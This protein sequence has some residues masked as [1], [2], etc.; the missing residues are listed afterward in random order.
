MRI[1]T[2]NPLEGRRLLVAVSGSIAAVKVP[3]L[4]SSLVKA[5]AKVRCLVTPSASELVSPVSLATLSRHR[6]Y[7]DQDQWAATEPRPLH[8]HLAEWAE[9]VIVAPLSAASLAR[10]THGLADGLLASTLLACERPIVAV[11]AMNTAMW[12]NQA[13]KRNWL[14]LKTFARVLTIGPGMGLLACDRVG[15]GRM[16]SPELIQLACESVLFTAD[17]SGVVRHDWQGLRLL[18]S[19]GPTV[20]GIDAARLMTN[21]SSGKM[22]VLLA[23]AARFRGAQVDLVHGPLRLPQQWLE[24]L[25]TYPVESSAEM[26]S[27]LMALHGC[28][29]AVAMAA[30]VSD[31]RHTGLIEISKSAKQA[32][33]MSLKEGW[34][35][36]PDLLAELA[37]KRPAGQKLIGF[38][39]LTGD[40]ASLIERA[41]TKFA[42]KGCDLLMVNPIDRPGQGFDCSENGGWILGKDGQ[43]RKMPVVAKM[44]LAHQLLDALLDLRPFLKQ[45]S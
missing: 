2:R 16:A 4:V 18:V 22:G 43:E 29:D 41:A 37:L 32:L 31:V 26:R 40:D 17:E 30:A 5:G 15:D 42:D 8:V 9:L 12:A 10:W 11:A 28:V 6:C 39:A 21:R 19:A 44:L 35:P 20:E 24:G 33:L 7:Q 27:Q 23:Q 38:A 36:V 1:E 34:E 14:E 3:L 25:R 13:V 45:L